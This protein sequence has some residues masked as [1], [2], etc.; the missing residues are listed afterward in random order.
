MD[1]YCAICDLFIKPQSKYKQFKSNSHKE[2]D[3]CK[4]IKLTIENTDINDVD[5][6]F[7]GYNIELNKK[8][9][10]YLVKCEF[11]LVF[12]D[13]QFCPYITSKLFDN[14]TMCFQQ[15]F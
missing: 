3:K 13:Y 12:N 2:F 1:Y 11:E 7:Y 5:K 6:S 9:K 4:R 10:Y 8:Y 14:K 15:N